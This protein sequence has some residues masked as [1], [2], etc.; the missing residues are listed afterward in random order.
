MGRTIP[1]GSHCTQQR[2]S[3]RCDHRSCNI[4]RIRRRQVTS[5]NHYMA[6][7]A[8]ELARQTGFPGCSAARCLRRSERN[9]A[10][11][12]VRAPDGWR[13][14]PPRSDR[15]STAMNQDDSQIPICSLSTS[16]GTWT[17]S[18]DAKTMKLSAITYGFP[19]YL[20]NSEF[21]D[22][23]LATS[24]DIYVLIRAVAEHKPDFPHG[25]S[26]MKRHRTI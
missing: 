23:E 26:Q 10:T 20:T 1:H 8:R 11:D 12:L 5:H 7:L 17:I 2:N 16:L 4:A 14:V 21:P 3:R 22:F 9:P 24:K 15:Y 18:T 6:D 13:R 25:T 19:Y